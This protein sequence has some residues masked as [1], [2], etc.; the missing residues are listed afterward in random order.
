MTFTYLDSP[1][2]LLLIAGRDQALAFIGLPEGRSILRPADTW[3]RD[4]R[5]W[6]EATRQLAAYFAGR[7]TVFDL[8]LRPEGTPFQQQVW[9][10]LRDIPYGETRSYAQVAAALGRP[11]A[12][13]AVG[14]ANGSNPLPIVVPCHRVIGSDGTLTGYGGGLAAKRWLLDLER[15]NRPPA[16]EAGDQGRLW[17]S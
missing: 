16:L 4:D 1:L 7:L 5:A 2:G 17:T 13:R 14:R 12:V 3:R 8:P 10:A 6:P 9:R 15:R 11:A